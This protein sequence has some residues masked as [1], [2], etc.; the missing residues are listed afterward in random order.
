MIISVT[1]RQLFRRC[2][3]KWDYSSHNRRSLSPLVNAPALEMGTLVHSVLAEW[4]QTPT[5]DPIEIFDDQC[6][7]QLL[8][9]VHNYQ[10]RIGCKPSKEELKPITEAFNLSRVM[11]ENYQKQWRTPLPPGFRLID[12]EQTITVNIPNTLHCACDYATCKCAHYCI[13]QCQCIPTYLTSSDPLA[14]ICSC[15]SQHQ[16]EA[17]FDGI[18]ADEHDQL[19][20]IERKTYARRPSIEE[21]DRKDQF[22]AYMWALNTLYPNQVV[23]VSYDGLWKRDHISAGKSLSDLFLRRVLLRNSHELSEFEQELALEALDMAA[24]DLRIYKNEPVLG[25]CW[26]CN[27]RPLCDAQSRNIDF[28][29]VSKMYTKVDRKQW[30]HEVEV[31]D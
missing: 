28:Q 11:I 24:P 6:T 17:T 19:F 5:D 30:R 23:G 26:D 12:N 7:K 18:M 31:S 2:R 29:N 15:L 4:T 27:F 16:L 25:G 14:T 21:L 9:I 8:S 22:L 13:D 3:R 20:I 10:E 1:E